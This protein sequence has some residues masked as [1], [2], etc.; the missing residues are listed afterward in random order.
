[1][2]P[3]KR[4]T[5]PDLMTGQGFVRESTVLQPDAARTALIVSK[6]AN[7]VIRERF[8]WMWWCCDNPNLV[9]SAQQNGYT[10]VDENPATSTRWCF[11]MW[12]SVTLVET[13]MIGP[14]R[15]PSSAM[16]LP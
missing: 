12:Q 1:M 11:A 13:A 7:P 16:A 4:P 5:G 3:L 10:I 2:A 15:R 6:F 8:P 14:V 9:F